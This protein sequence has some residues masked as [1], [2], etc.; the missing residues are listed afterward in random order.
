MAGLV[1]IFGGSGFVGRHVVQLLARDGWQ[2]RVAVRKPSKARFLQPLGNVA[3]ITPVYARIQDAPRVA[4]VVSGADL[5]INLTGILYE[6]YRQSFDG[7]HARGAETVAKASA[8]AGASAFVHMS[9]LGA[10]GGSDSDYARTKGKGEEAVRAAFQSASIVR[11]SIIFGPEDSFFNRFAQMAQFSPFLPLIGGG[12]TKYQPVYVG[13]VAQAIFKCATDSR[14]AGETYELGGP[15]IYSFKELLE[16]MLQQTRRK[17]RLI[18]LPFGLAEVIARFAELSPV[19]PLT[20]DQVKL[21]RHDNVISPKAK[22]LADLGISPKTVEA[23]LPT[24][25]DQYRIGGRYKSAATKAG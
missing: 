6:S 22:T 7:V 4:E 5:V 21:L 16:L 1:T 2:I 19:P 3:Q 13:D 11:P 14:Y 18:S 17:N 10:D 23:V 15:K 25:M 24:F 20:R 9:A 12:E 8:E